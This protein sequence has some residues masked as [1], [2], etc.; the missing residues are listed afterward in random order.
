MCDSGDGDCCCKGGI[1][2]IRKNYTLLCLVGIWVV[3][4]VLVL[5]IVKPSNAHPN[6]SKSIQ[7]LPKKSKQIQS[8][9]DIGHVRQELA[10]SQIFS[11]CFGLVWIGLDEFG[12]AFEGFS[13]E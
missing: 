5:L 8:H 4:I 3:L 11:H 2:V 6:S 10:Q 13:A 12:W 1:Y 9:I 7:T